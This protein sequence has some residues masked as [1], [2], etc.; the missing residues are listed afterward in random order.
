MV[1]LSYNGNLIPRDKFCLSASN[2]AFRYG[3][4]LFETIRVH[5]SVMLWAEHH[6]RRLTQGASVLQ[7]NPGTGWS[8]ELFKDQVNALYRENH[9]E[10]GAARIRCTL[11]RDE[12]GY[13][14]PY[15]NQASLLIESEALETGTFVLNN[16]G[17]TLT[18]YDE[19]RKHQNKL[20]Q[21]KS[22]N[23]QLYV[24]ASLYKRNL[25]FGDALLLNQE[26]M[27]AEATASNVFIYLNGTF[28][29][30]AIHQ[31]CVEGIMRAVIIE[32][33]H[34]N[35]MDIIEDRISPADLEKAEEVFLSNAVQGIRWVK[36]FNNRKY[37]NKM[38]SVLLSL[39]SRKA[40]DYVSKY[41]KNQ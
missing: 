11:F 4:G 41:V 5:D 10:G 37:N 30:P 17:I 15:S 8:V 21:T 40:A 6:Y 12:G 34:E 36:E 7:M 27:I 13:Y 1:M 28:K 38:A 9:K 39:L 32:I 26:G 31:G 29:T 23:A 25:G 19:I 16:K 33:M 24:L 2:R 18:L 35:G 14:T 22:I 20:S 3:D